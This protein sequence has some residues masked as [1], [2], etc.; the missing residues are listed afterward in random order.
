MK[1]TL[2]YGKEFIYQQDIEMEDSLFEEAIQEHAELIETSVDEIMNNPHL[3]CVAIQ[4]KQKHEL[5]FDESNVVGSIFHAPD[6]YIKH[7]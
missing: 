1:I 6:A 3:I 5:S 4:R 7:I 2:Q